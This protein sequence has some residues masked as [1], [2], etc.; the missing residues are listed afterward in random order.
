[1]TIP[2]PQDVPP[3]WTTSVFLGRESHYLAKTIK[4]VIFMRV[5]ILFLI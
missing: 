4:E 1:M 5:V 2:T 3:V